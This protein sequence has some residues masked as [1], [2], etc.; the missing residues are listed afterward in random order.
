MS[1]QDIDMFG[2][3]LIIFEL[4]LCG[5]SLRADSDPGRANLNIFVPSLG[6]PKTAARVISSSSTAEKKVVRHDGV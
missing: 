3:Y 4:F 6:L 1:C 2:Q 5:Q